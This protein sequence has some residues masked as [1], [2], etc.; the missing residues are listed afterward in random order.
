M[1][2]PLPLLF[3]LLAAGTDAAVAQQAKPADPAST[4]VN[5]S[6]TRQPKRKPPKFLTAGKSA[7]ASS[8]R[9]EAPAGRVATPVR[10]APG[11]KPIKR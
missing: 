9:P 1:I 4:A 7:T 3:F 2:R 6:L 5:A 8:D 11:G 10:Q